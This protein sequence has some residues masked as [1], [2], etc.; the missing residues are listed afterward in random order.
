MQAREGGR[1]CGDWHRGS[2]CMQA[3]GGGQKCGDWHRGSLS[4]FKR[5]EGGAH[6]LA[7]QRG[8]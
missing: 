8:H 6:W 4:T 5:G 3:R 1:K 2:L 7:D